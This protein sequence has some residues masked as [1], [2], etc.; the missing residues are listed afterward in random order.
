MVILDCHISKSI[1]GNSIGNTNTGCSLFVGWSDRLRSPASDVD[2]V[3]G[4]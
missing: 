4:S 1:Y 3:G 2:K